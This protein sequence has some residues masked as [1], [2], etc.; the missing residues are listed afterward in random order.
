L[1]GGGGQRPEAEDRKI[2]FLSNVPNVHA[3]FR[4]SL[5]HVE[6]RRHP[7][8]RRR[9]RSTHVSHVAVAR[10]VTPRRARCF[11]Y[12]D[13]RH[14]TPH[15]ARSPRCSPHCGDL[16]KILVLLGSAEG[17]LEISNSWHRSPR[18]VTPRHAT[19]RTPRLPRRGPLPRHATSHTLA[20]ARHVACHTVG[21]YIKF[22]FCS[23]RPEA[24][25]KF[26]ILS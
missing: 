10:H 14:V 21:S 8:S 9:R 16:Y 18:H 13:P 25:W 11:S 22:V 6:R 4:R 7:A 5:L 15:R 24:L 1:E 19:S 23:G 3:F 20:D 26:R 2:T 12:V 17:P